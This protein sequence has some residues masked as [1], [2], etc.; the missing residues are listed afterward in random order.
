M[1]LR[2]IA[3]KNNALLL[4]SIIQHA[5]KIMEQVD[6]M[7]RN[8]FFNDEELIEELFYTKKTLS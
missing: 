3:Q 8:S 1:V 6:V 2:Y 5:R 7:E 4:P